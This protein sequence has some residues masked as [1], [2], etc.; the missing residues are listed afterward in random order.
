MFWAVVGV[1]PAGAALAGAA[2][3]GVL[4]EEDA[5]EENQLVVET[6]AAAALA[7]S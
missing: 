3:L 5:S 6:G 4:A 1:V 2:L 7:L